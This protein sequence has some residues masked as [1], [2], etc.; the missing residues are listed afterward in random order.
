MPS[1]AITDDGS[2][3]T[4]GRGNYGRLGHG[5]SNDCFVPTLVSALEG[6]HVTKVSCGSGDSHTLCV[7]LDGKVY[8]W[9]DGDYGK[10]GN[11]ACQAVFAVI[12][13]DMFT[14]RGGSDCSNV[15]VLINKLQD[16]EIVDVYCGA[17][18]SVA[19][20]KDGRVFSWGKGEGWKLGHATEEHVRY[21]EVIEGLQGT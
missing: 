11:L 5:K 4:W 16:I 1:A 19:L 12:M 18:F 15:P 10:L 7:T 8:S 14:G 6:I 13:T 17:Q 2:L 20:S 21:P 3:Y 9:G